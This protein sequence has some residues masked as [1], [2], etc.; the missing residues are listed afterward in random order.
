GTINTKI[1]SQKYT[2]LLPKVGTTLGLDFDKLSLY[3][4]VEYSYELGDM[5]KDIGFNYVGFDGVGKLEKDELE[6]GTTSLKAGANYKI[7]S[8]SVRASIGKN[9]GKR[10]NLFGNVSLGYTF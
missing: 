8:F 10:D 7:A 6:C 4:S 9:F 1:E 5:E 3:S 2:S